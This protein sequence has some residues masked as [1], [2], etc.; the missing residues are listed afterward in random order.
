MSLEKDNLV[1]SSDTAK[2]WEGFSKRY[3]AETSHDEIIELEGLIS[4]DEFKDHYVRLPYD[5]PP[6]TQNCHW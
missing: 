1:Q 2:V 5:S 6:P 4:A 3:V